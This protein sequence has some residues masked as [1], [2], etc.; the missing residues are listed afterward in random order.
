MN[1]ERRIV[2]PMALGLVGVLCLGGL[3]AGAAQSGNLAGSTAQQ[4]SVQGARPTDTITG[5]IHD[6]YRCSCVERYRGGA[7]A[8]VS[9]C[10][11]AREQCA[12]IDVELDCEENPDGPDCDYLLSC[13]CDCTALAPTTEFE[14][15]PFEDIVLTGIPDL[16][17][18][19]FMCGNDAQHD[20][21]V[22]CGPVSAAMLIYWWAQQGYGGL[23]D[24]FLVGNGS[25][26][27]TQ[28]HDWQA[29]VR[30]LRANYLDGGICIS[31]QYATPM[32]TMTTGIQ[33]YIEHAGYRVD[34][35]HW[36]V[37]DDCNAGAADELTGPEGL[38]LIKDE[39]DA[40]RPVIMGMNAG[41]TFDW[42]IPVYENGVWETVYMGELSNGAPVTGI[43]NHYAVVTGYRRVGGL[44][45]LTL[46]LGWE[47]EITDVNVAWNPGGKWLHLYT[48]H[49]TSRRDGDPW[50][51]IDW[52]GQETY[53]AA[54]AEAFSPPFIELSH[55]GTTPSDTL[56]LT[57]VAGTSCGIAREGETVT[58]YDTTHQLETCVTPG[59]LPTE[60]EMEDVLA[61]QWTSGTA[62]AGR[63]D[64]WNGGGGGSVPILDRQDPLP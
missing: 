6:G 17:Q 58:Y 53:P 34:V 47:D 8:S 18:F 62:E 4:T 42:S 9:S 37:C 54:L 46:N 14:H 2:A 16:W 23:V 35:G 25:D 5:T 27:T 15:G 55:L 22:G 31:G 49:I 19:D 50:C 48:V 39:L 26:P 52:P 57:A 44:D 32:W 43:I 64:T 11:D 41:K 20:N 30:D 13:E 1:S 36:K 38:N 24:H 29:L 21:A 45:V 56:Q 12:D 61:G 7:E 63:D 33:R 60:Q 10:D 59:D 51:S 40:G 3:A 28:E